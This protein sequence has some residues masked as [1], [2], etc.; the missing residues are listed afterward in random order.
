MKKLLYLPFLIPVILFG[1]ASE[2][3]KGMHFESAAFSE[4][5][6]KA[7][8]EN[9]IILVDAYTTWCGPCKWMAKNIFT[10]DTVASYYN[11]N[12]INAKIDMEKGEGIDI[13]KKYEVMCYPTFLFINKDGQLLHRKSGALDVKEFVELGS[14]AADPSRQFTTYKNNY[15]S[16]KITPDE[17]REY[18]LIRG[19]S[20]LPVREELA[21]YFSTQTDADL[22][23]PH[24]WNLLYENSTNLDINSRAFK[25]LVDHKEEY[26]KLYAPKTDRDGTVEDVIKESYASALR[27]YIKGKNKEEY[28]KLKEEVLKKNFP[29]SGEVIA[30]ADMS[31]HRSY[32]DWV[33]YAQ[34]A[35]TYIDKY[36]K[37]DSNALNSIAWSFYENVEDKGMLAKAEGWAKHS[38]DLQPGY[39]NYD[40]YAAILY[41]LGKKAEARVTAEKAI[42]LAKKEGQDYKETQDLLDK[43]KLLK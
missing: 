17:M 30:E 16:G 31:L 38:V 14:N 2:M 26:E 7:K 5:L 40:T 11:A 23:K 3:N 36:K 10:N 25:Y 21:K 20:C 41:K 27:T 28:K 18:V 37:E 32:G 24:N 4:L 35:V 34:T 1:Q 43:I 19:H 33:Q 13:R 9:K 6:E 29:F 8:K 15:D 39:A 22:I 12:Y 42:E